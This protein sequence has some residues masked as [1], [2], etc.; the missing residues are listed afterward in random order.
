MKFSTYDTG[1]IAMNYQEAME[2]MEK[3]GTYGIVPGLDSIRELCRR[4]GNPQDELKFVHIA[5]TN[6]KGST[7]PIFPAS[8]RLPDTV[9]E[10]IYHLLLLNIVKKS[11]SESRRS[12][13]RICVKDWRS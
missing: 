9:W 8:Y 3:V 6:G 7:L 13:I 4:L 2:Y 12:R 1:E 5:G 11:R 10:N